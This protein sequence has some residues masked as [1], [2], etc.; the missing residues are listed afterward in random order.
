MRHELVNAQVDVLRMFLEKK[1][2]DELLE[3]VGRLADCAAL[4]FREE[5]ALMASMGSIADPSH[6]ERHAG[7]PPDV[8]TC[9]APNFSKGSSQ[10]CR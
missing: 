2:R 6:G 8:E 9:T 1:P 5:E 10:P 3:A 7:V 4:S